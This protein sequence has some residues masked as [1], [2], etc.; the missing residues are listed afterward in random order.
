MLEGLLSSKALL[1]VRDEQLLDQ[2]ETLCRHGSKLIMLEV[3]VTITDLLEDLLLGVGLK[4]KIS[5]NECVQDDTE[6]PKI[7]LFAI[8]TLDYFWCHIVRC[9]RNLRQAFSSM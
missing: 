7:R 6:R 4:R 5:A 9:P 3:V 2:V 8:V 1:W